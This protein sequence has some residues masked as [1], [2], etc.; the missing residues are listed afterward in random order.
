ML[1]GGSS[2]NLFSSSPRRRELLE[3]LGVPFR[4]CPV[5]AD[6][7]LPEGVDFTEAIR[8]V[9]CRKMQAGLNRCGGRP[10]WAVA[11]DTL[12]EAEQILL[13]KP[14]NRE[15]AGRMIRQL[16]GRVH[17]VHTAFAVFSPVSG[18]VESEC[19]TTHVRFRSLSNAEVEHYLD[20]GEWQG[21]AGGYRIQDSGEI[22]VEELR[23]LWSTVV[24]LPLGP[25][26]GMLTSMSYA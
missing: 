3:K 4:V 12:V 7:T 14:E 17:R 25:L 19:H 13:G 11:A 10:A 18:A 23:G 2:I 15:E 9:A 20:T 5:E 26:Y 21:A 22:L 1:Q 16:S 6:E 24:G 8:T